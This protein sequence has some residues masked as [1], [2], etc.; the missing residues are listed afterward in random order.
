MD[1]ITKP[2]LKAIQ[3]ITKPVLKTLKPILNPIQKLVKSIDA[4]MVIMVLLTITMICIMRRF[5]MKENFSKLTRYFYMYNPTSKNASYD[6]RGD[7]LA[8]PKETTGAFYESSLEQN[9][10]NSRLHKDI[11]EIND[12]VEF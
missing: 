6:T 10:T 9:H 3:P 11:K 7:I 1:K 12:T 8:I 4:T 2:V 5:L